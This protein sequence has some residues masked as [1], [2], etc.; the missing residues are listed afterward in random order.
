MKT[1]LFT[2]ALSA[3]T[4]M[5]T[6]TVVRAQSANETAITKTIEAEKDA[7]DAADYKV[8]L[9]HWANLPYASFLTAFVTFS[10]RV[11][12]LDTKA[13]S[14]NAEARYLEKLN[15]DWKIVSV[16]VVPKPAK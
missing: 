6:P 8:Y 15:G 13:V 11:E 14:E 4:L 1:I 3:A 16:A 7:G 9:S 10:Q 5:A 12:S 2:L